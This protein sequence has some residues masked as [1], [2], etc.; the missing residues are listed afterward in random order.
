M[1]T[2][3]KLK[4]VERHIEEVSGY[5]EQEYLRFYSLCVNVLGVGLQSLDVVM[6][7]GFVET[8]SGD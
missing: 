7:D 4:N 6:D 2:T 1:T 3:Q 8:P 5:K